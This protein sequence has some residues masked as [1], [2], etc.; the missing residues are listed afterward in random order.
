MQVNKITFI[1]YTINKIMHDYHY[2]TAVTF[3]LVFSSKQQQT[4]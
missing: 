4:C 2:V 3:V 1:I